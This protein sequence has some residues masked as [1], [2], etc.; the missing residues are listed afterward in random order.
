LLSRV[1]KYSIL[2]GASLAVFS[3]CGKDAVDDPLV[4]Y[5]DF[6][7]DI[8]FSTGSKYYAWWFRLRTINRFK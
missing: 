6:D 4:E 3:G 5:T 2:T 8:Q 7:P 1:G